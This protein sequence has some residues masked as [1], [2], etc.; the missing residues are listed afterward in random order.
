MYTTQM[1]PALTVGPDLGDR[2]SALCRLDA[3]GQVVERRTLA[4]THEAL[5]RYF[6][7]LPSAQ[8]ILEAGTHSPWVS[9]F[10][11]HLGHE[12]MVA[13]PAALRRP[14]RGKTDRV[15]AE[16]LARWGRA[17]PEL[18]APIQ[19]RRAAAQADLALLKARDALVRSRTLLINHVRGSVKSFG[20]RIPSCSAESFTKIA[21]AHLPALLFGALA[22][23]ESSS[24]T[25][26]L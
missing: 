14:K 15:D 9:R 1:L 17:D 5:N 10:L 7:A 8:V 3:A 16:A 2:K 23:A 26:Q 20:G 11:Q 24:P 18:L 4:T 6:A 19:H 12:V 22:V 21:E 13:N 25:R